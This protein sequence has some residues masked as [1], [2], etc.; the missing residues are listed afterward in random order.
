MVSRLGITYISHLGPIGWWFSGHWRSGLCSVELSHSPARHKHAH[1]H[2]HTPVPAVPDQPP[3]S[4]AGLGVLG[5]EASGAV[6]DC[7]GCVWP[8]D[9]ENGPPPPSHLKVSWWNYLESRI[10]ERISVP[11]L[12]PFRFSLLA[13][14]ISIKNKLF[15]KNIRG[16]SKQFAS[17]SAFSITYI[18]YNLTTW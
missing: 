11:S 8:T 4:C 17:E 12:T 16:N 14:K 2:I 9:I 13:F 1:T 15:K 10:P 18:H 5:E 6:S 3:V 7:T